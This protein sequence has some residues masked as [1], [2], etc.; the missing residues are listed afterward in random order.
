MNVESVRMSLYLLQVSLLARVKLAGPPLLFGLYHGLLATLPVGPP[1][2]LSIR[3]FLIGGNLS[4]IAAVLGLMTGQLL[5]F[6]SIFHSPLY[7]LVVKPH[8]VTVLIIPYLLFY[9]FRIKDLP[10]YQILRSTNSVYNSQIYNIF[11]DSFIFQILNPI[12]LPSPVLA[13]LIQLFLFRHSNNVL[14]LISSFL[15]W[16]VGHILLIYLS[17]LLLFRI[18]YDSPVVYLLMKHVIYKTFSIIIFI[19]ILLY[20]GKAPVSTSTK[21]FDDEIV[22]FDINFVQLPYQILWMFKLWPTS[23]F[24]QSKANRPLRYIENSR[25]SGDSPVRKQVSNYFFDNCLT[26]GKQRLSST[27]LPSLSIF[28]GQLGSFFE[29]PEKSLPHYSCKDWMLDQLKKTEAL[30]NELKDRIRF[31]DNERI[32]WKAMERKTGLIDTDQGKLPKIYDPFISQSYRIRIPIPQSFWILS[33]LMLPGTGIDSYYAEKYSSRYN[34]IENWVSTKYQELNRDGIPLPWEP[35]LPRDVKTTFILMFETPYDVLLNSFLEEMDL[36]IDLSYIPLTWDQVFEL[37]PTEQALF[38]IE[39]RE[40]CGVFNWGPLLNRLPIEGERFSELRSILKIEELSRELAHNTELLF[41][42]GFDTVGGASEI[43][44]RKLKNVGT[45]IGTPKMNTIRIVKRFS[46]T[47]DFRRKLIKGSMRSRRRK[48]LVWKLFQEKPHSPFFLRLMEI[49][50]SL[51]STFKESTIIDSD[52]LITDTV[53][54]T[55]L[56]REQELSSPTSLQDVE[57]LKSDRSPSVAARLDVASIQ[58]G[59]GLLLL[60]QSILRKYVKL[61]VLVTLKNIGRISFLQAPEWDEDWNEWRKESYI[62][63][64]YD[65]EEFPDTHLP[66]RW[67]REGLQIKILYPFQLKPWHTHKKKRSNIREDRANLKNIEAQKST[68]EHRLERG[69]FQSTYLTVWGFQTDVPFGDIKRDP[70]FWKPIKKELRKILGSSLSLRIKQIRQFYLKLGI[71]ANLEPSELNPFT[72]LEGIRKIDSRTDVTGR[73]DSVYT[74]AK[75]NKETLVNHKLRVAGANTQSINNDK[76]FESIVDSNGKLVQDLAAGFESETQLDPNGLRHLLTERINRNERSTKSS[77]II[78]LKIDDKL[79]DTKLTSLFRFKKQLV[80]IQGMTFRLRIWT[81]ELIDR[82][83]LPTISISFQKLNRT[84]V[85]YFTEFVA[86]QVQLVGVTNT[87]IGAGEEV[88]HPNSSTEKK[89]LQVDRNQSVELLSQAYIY[90]NLWHRSIRDNLDLNHLIETMRDCQGVE[91]PNNPEELGG[92]W[93]WDD[94]QRDWNSSEGRD[95]T[96]DHY[97]IGK[98]QSPE[99]LGDTN[100]NKHKNYSI[101]CLDNQ[102]NGISHRYIDEHVK[103]FAEIQALLKQLRNLNPNDWEN[104]LDCLDR[105]NLPFRMWYKIA[106]HKWR[107]SVGNLNVYKTRKTEIGFLNDQNKYVSYEK[108]ENYSIYT[109][110]PSIRDRIVNLNKRRKYSYSLYSFMDF[111]GDND[112]Q[113]FTVCQNAAEREVCS[114]NR[115]KKLI[116]RRIFHRRISNRRGEFDSKFDSILWTVPDPAKSRNAYGAESKF[117]PKT[118]ILQKD[119]FVDTDLNEQFEG[120]N[121]D[122]RFQ[123]RNINSDD[124]LLRERGNLYYIFQWKWKSEA[125]DRGL[126]GLGDLIALTSVL[127]NEQDLTAFCVNMGIDSDLLNLFFNEEKLEILDQL[128]VVS[129]HRLPRVFDDQ[130]LMY[131]MVS[132]LPKFRNSFERRLNRHVL[133]ECMPR[134]CLINREISNSYHYLYNIEDLLLPRRRRESRF[135]RSLPISSFVKSE[136]NLLDSIPG[137]EG[138][139]KNEESRYLSG[140]Q[141]IK[142]FIW[143][144]YRLEELARMNR[145]SLNTNNGSRF[146]MLKIRIYPTII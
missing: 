95:A 1:Q 109:E 100:N 131:K 79:K 16:L 50:V 113:E 106:P 112:I 135:L 118:C 4:G 84:F 139:Y 121:I 146:A 90:D 53:G 59:R 81:A 6:L 29:N 142:R 14:F 116:A 20:L 61:P 74:E 107:G 31:L 5:L 21:K 32:F 145:F 46:K 96:K 65:G 43:R 111:P 47:S 144:S 3:A 78:K 49:P 27:A 104:W 62:R 72:R 98:G 17:R 40:R 134:L 82:Y 140:T 108:R 103:N 63:C 105:Y 122:Y 45:S 10:N 48:I 38:F 115:M 56:Q 117:V 86:F 64:T 138:A 73:D 110:N 141:K 7:V 87:S 23:L 91:K 26:D 57:R 35:L 25:F 52:K 93:N 124:M 19:N 75:Y 34:K 66:S 127:E 85:C 51:Q 41:D 137:E 126:E 36:S 2:I 132:I 89:I 99:S 67:L 15:G 77:H 18:E 9:W 12:L 125:L 69:K 28:K 120:L 130:I 22:L 71:P 44:N 39:L 24:D 97:S 128:F 33:D 83:L 133:D 42:N 11:L 68:K 55:N 123:Q 129:A 92:I 114:E 102:T 143:P 94:T 8:V 58:T 136:K 101:G 54:G 70:S 76:D 13:R 88:E 80:D 119:A 37:S 60:L 30:N